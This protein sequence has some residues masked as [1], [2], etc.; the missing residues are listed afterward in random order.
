MQNSFAGQEATANEECSENGLHSGPD[1]E[2]PASPGGKR[3]GQIAVEEEEGDEADSEE[4][5]Q[6]HRIGVRLTND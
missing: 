5:L 3:S 6:D 4:D 2:E 1:P